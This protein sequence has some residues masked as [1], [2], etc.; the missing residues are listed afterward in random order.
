MF[1]SH[2]ILLSQTPENM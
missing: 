1:Y 2:L